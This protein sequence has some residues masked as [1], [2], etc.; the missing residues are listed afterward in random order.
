MKNKLAKIS[1]VLAQEFNLGSISKLEEPTENME[2]DFDNGRLPYVATKFD[3]VLARKDFPKGLIPFFNRGEKHVCAVCDYI[4][5]CEFKGHLYVLL[6]ELKKGANKVT[7]QLF[8]GKCIANFIISTANRVFKIN[9]EPRVRLISIRG[10]HIKP[11]Q[12]QRE[13]EYDENSFH[14]FSSS[15]F[16]LREYLH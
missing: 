9:L 15:K 4:I 12:K 16:W 5:F 3:R 8:A 13:V 11:K 1:S 10:R 14:T 2:V 7:E 6:V